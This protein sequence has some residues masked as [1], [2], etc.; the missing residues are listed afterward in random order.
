MARPACPAPITTVVTVRIGAFPHGAP[1]EPGN[2]SKHL[3]SDVR[4]IGHD[5]I[6]RRALLRL[7]DESFNIF[8]FRVGID[9]VAYL[10]ATEAVADVAVDAKDALEVHVPFDYRR[11][12]AQLDVAML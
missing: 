9:F 4:R 7:R 6:D 10:D 3:D 11:D 2:D 12:R 1:I 8:A 5:V